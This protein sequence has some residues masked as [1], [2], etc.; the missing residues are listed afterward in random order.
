[1][2][3]LH[4]GAIGVCVCA[5]NQMSADKRTFN[6]RMHTALRMRKERVCVLSKGA[7][8]PT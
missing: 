7:A 6:M 5:S 8:R 1:M 2:D 4:E 3:L